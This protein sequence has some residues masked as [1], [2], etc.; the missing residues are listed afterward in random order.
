MRFEQLS[1]GVV[2]YLGDSREHLPELERVDVVVTSPPYGQQRDYGKKIDDWRSVVSCLARVPD[3]GG[4]QVLVNL[5][6]IHR[7]GSVVPYWQDLIT[8]MTA[9][10][11]RHFGWYVWDQMS[12]MAGDWNGRLAPSFEFILHFNRE[13]RPV[14]KTKPT[15]GG[16]NHGPGIKN[17]SG[18]AT[19]KTNHGKPV[20]P[21]KI[22]DNVIRVVRDTS[23][24][25]GADGYIAA[26]PARFP[27]AF[28]RELIAPFSDPGQIVCDPFMGSGTTGVA[29]VKLGREFIGIELEPTYFDIA[30]RRISEALKQPDMFIAPP[31]PAKQETFGI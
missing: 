22:P 14:N 4:T 12:G 21:V 27:V 11:W 3:C 15:L 24:G 31:K 1:D 20:Q 13:A 10:G 18:I 26:H 2:L 25:L 19:Q 17:A 23:N 5:G 30:C 29:A 9:S 6:M 8:D 28:A 16:K 7:D